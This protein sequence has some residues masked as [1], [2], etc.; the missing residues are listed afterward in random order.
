[1]MAT[2]RVSANT[3]GKSYP[4]IDIEISSSLL[5]WEHKLYLLENIKIAEI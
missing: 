5:S 3:D 2:H 4:S 1:V